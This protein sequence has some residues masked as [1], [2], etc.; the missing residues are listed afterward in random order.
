MARTSLGQTTSTLAC[1]CSSFSSSPLLLRSLRLDLLPA[2][3]FEYLW[4]YLGDSLNLW[5]SMCVHPALSLLSSIAVHHALS[6]L[7]SMCVHPALSLGKYKAFIQWRWGASVPDPL[8]II[9]IIV[10]MSLRCSL[11]FQWFC[12]NVACK[13]KGFLLISFAFPRMFLW[14]S[15]CWC[16]YFLLYI[17]SF[18][19]LDSRSMCQLSLS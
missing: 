14:F 2:A 7:S 17:L 11:H 8:V 15:R 6:L 9:I 3:F 16:C 1:S 10:I 18:L 19:I 4:I 13:S 12:F 5:T